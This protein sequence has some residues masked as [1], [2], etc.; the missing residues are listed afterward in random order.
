MQDNCRDRSVI[1]VSRLNGT[2]TM[3]LGSFR[4]AKLQLHVKAPNFITHDIG[5]T[6]FRSVEP[7]RSEGSSVLQL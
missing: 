6:N 2:V 5:A 3:S 7:A 4:K 1:H